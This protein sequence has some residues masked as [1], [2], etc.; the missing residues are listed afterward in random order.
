MLA[1]QLDRFLD[2]QSEDAVAVWIVLGIVIRQLAG[3]RHGET[4]GGDRRSMLG[5]AVAARL[6]LARTDVWN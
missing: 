6:K 5:A 4:P 1:R 2:A 3:D